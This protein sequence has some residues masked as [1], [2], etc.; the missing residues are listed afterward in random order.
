MNAL[1]QPV[2]PPIGGPEQADAIAERRRLGDVRRDDVADAGDRDIAE[3][4]LSAKGDAGEDQ[5]LGGR[6]TS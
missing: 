3:R 1:R 5:P 2:R 6:H 4:R